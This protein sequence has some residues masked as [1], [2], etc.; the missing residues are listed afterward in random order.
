[1]ADGSPAS[2]SFGVFELNLKDSEV[3]KDGYSVKLA[4]QPFSVLALLAS[5]AGQVVARE[6]IQRLV[7]GEDTF[8]DFDL[9]L[10]QCIRQ[11]RS[12]LGD[13]A[14]SPR[15]IET[16]SRKGYR[17]IAP[18]KTEPVESETPDPVAKSAIG[19]PGQ[20]LG[21]TPGAANPS[22]AEKL[23]P[24]LAGVPNPSRI[25]RRTLWVVIGACIAVVIALII[26]LGPGGLDI[27]YNPANSIRSLAVLPFRNL[28][29][30]PSQEYFTE[31]VT[32]QLITDLAQIPTLRI[33]SRTSVTQYKDTRK[34]LPVIAGELK[35][36]AVVEGSVARSGNRVRITAQLV[37]AHPERHLWA[38]TFERSTGDALNMQGEI[39]ESIATE[40]RAK[41]TPQERTLLDNRLPENAAAEGAYLKGHYHF[42]RSQSQL[43]EGMEAPLNKSI[44]YFSRQLNSILTSP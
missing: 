11:I 22:Q 37:E 30:D 34:S 10:N 12:A 24:H 26:V 43:D 38:K 9:G 15:Y 5:R 29:A 6:E 2:I 39:A 7:W 23:P 14:Q 42:L 16:L 28:S 3:R 20:V 33:I 8:V 18:V 41:L 40:I 25:R 44:A 36:D 13:D 35:V 17:F 32:D 19:L 21:E 31:G 4:P 1:M 27:T